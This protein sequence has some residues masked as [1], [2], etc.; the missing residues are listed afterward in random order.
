MEMYPE[1]KFAQ[2]QAQLYDW[3]KEQYPNL[4]KKIKEKVKQGQFI[5]G[6]FKY[7]K[8][9]RDGNLMNKIVGRVLWNIAIRGKF[10]ET[11]FIRTQ[12]FQR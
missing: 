9:W 10:R 11:I 2:S 1:Y 7:K 6:I 8:S 12:I 5:P 3:V 4:Y